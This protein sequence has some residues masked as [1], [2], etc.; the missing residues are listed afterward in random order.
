L[1]DWAKFIVN[2][3]DLE[4]NP[5][6]SKR[7]HQIL[8]KNL[9]NTSQNNKDI[10]RQLFVQKKCIPTK[11]GMK[12]PNEAYFENVN[13]FPDL[14]TIDFQKPLSVRNLMELFGVRKVTKIFSLIHYF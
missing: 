8:A 1:V 4:A 5:E 10:I 7:V 12:I 9:N 6:F 2:K 11:Y 14:P 13:L 3:P